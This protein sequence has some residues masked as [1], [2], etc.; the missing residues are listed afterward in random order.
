MS[1]RETEVGRE[2]R[3]RPLGEKTGIHDSQW[4]RGGGGAELKLCPRI[5]CP[6]LPPVRGLD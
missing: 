1:P 5:W 3:A 2:G 6:E 4:G